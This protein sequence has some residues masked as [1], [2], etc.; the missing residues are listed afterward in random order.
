MIA[1]RAGLSLSLLVIASLAPL[2]RADGF[3]DVLDTPA[4]STPLAVKSLMSTRN[5]RASRARTAERL[6]TAT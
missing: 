6:R 5:A 3:V 2:A 1:V 4:Q